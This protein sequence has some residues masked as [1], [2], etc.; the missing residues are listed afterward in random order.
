MESID[1]AS[2]LLQSLALKL[3][4]TLN[5]ILY[6]FTCLALASSLWAVDLTPSKEDKALGF[7][8]KQ[9]LEHYHFNRN[10]KQVDDTFSK[11][12][13][14]ILLKRVD[15]QKRFFIQSDI[16]AFE[17]HKDKIDDELKTGRYQ[18][19]QLIGKK[20]D[21]NIEIIESACNQMLQKG[22]DFK[23]D[24]LFESD[25]EKLTYCKTFNELKERWRKQLKFQC[26]HSYL[27]YIEKQKTD[28]EV[29]QKLKEKDSENDKSTKNKP[30]V[31]KSDKKLREEAREKLSK[32][33]TLFFKRLKE[34]KHKDHYSRYFNAV[35]TTY[36]PHTTYM[37]PASKEDFDI[38]M[39]KSLEGI[40]AV[41][42]EDNDYT[43]VLRIVPGSASY[44]QGEL[45]AEDIILRVSEGD[46]GEEV[47]IRGMRIREVVKYIRGPKGTKVN[48]T[49][50]KPNNEIKV[51]S[52][53]RDIVKLDD[54]S[55]ARS[56]TIEKDKKTY[57]Y[58]YLPDFYRDFSGKTKKN[59]TDDV[60][61]E[62]KKLL[63]QNI[64][65]LVF[66][67]RGNG[68]GALEDAKQIAGLFIETGPIVQVKDSFGYIKVLNDRDREILYDGPLV[69]MVNQFSASASEIMAAALQDY[70]RAVVIGSGQTHGKGT[71][72]QIIPVQHRKIPGWDFDFGH[73]KLTIQKFYR[74]NGGSTQNKG[75]QPDI[76]FPYERA[77]L[78]SGERFLDHS[79]VWDQIP[80]LKYKHWNKKLNLDEI[81]EKSQKRIATNEVFKSV[82]DRYHVLKA[83]Y[84]KTK[85]S[86]KLTDITKEREDAEKAQKEFQKIF[87][88]LTG[89][90]EKTD[91]EKKKEKERRKTMSE[92]EIKEED[93]AK[94][95]KSKQTDPFIKEAVNILVDLEKN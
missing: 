13:F 59:C 10:Q 55:V 18:L 77:F 33:M 64:S 47:D 5:R 46:D 8:I 12:A 15:S 52:I 69:I 1:L 65:G 48:L 40:G 4:N 54:S 78:E 60:K 28:E 68:G 17:K 74:I 95:V 11:D 89:E 9:K 91:E 21:H 88:D 24:E 27:N 42:Q 49:V 3:R 62:I 82:E 72:Q 32:N 83:E 67:L 86:L 92:E 22:F 81:K 6:F 79:L 37:D 25:G 58:V 23:K 85:V 73:L 61:E 84:E 66:D 94:W 87:R 71:V 57:G 36:D 29:A 2:D 19:P 26:I 70:K 41:L 90:K 44:R 51:I 31:K 45:E 20:L 56:T 35:T 50:K 7:S 76:N 16:E 53:I 30:F 63:K 34:F 75:V 80:Q 39:Q 14:D 38:H 93:K 43:K